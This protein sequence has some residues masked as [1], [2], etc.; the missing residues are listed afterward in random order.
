L[1]HG[2]LAFSRPMFG[3]L[4]R[5]LLAHTGAEYC[6]VA[7]PVQGKVLEEAGL[8]SGAQSET[9]LAV[10]GWGAGAEVFLRRSGSD[11]LDDLIVTTQA[12]YHLV[13]PLE[14]D[15]DQPL[16]VYLR[17]DRKRGNLALA[18]R[19]LAT[20]RPAT[21]PSGG[22]STTSDRPARLPAQRHPEAPARQEAARQVPAAVGALPRRQP[23][24]LPVPRP[25]PSPQPR[26]AATDAVLPAG[27]RW[28]TDT[29]TLDRVLQALRRL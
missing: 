26:K 3:E 4:L 6:C 12:A 22:G 20:A 16:L 17:V 23:L 24:A 14:A 11:E 5:D 27:A 29:R 18:R 1:R 15:A 28:H 21:A 19:G 2:V 10:L 25:P 13:R 8:Q 7:D 9:S